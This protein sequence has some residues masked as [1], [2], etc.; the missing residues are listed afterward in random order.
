VNFRL[1]MSAGELFDLISPI[2][3]V[4]AAILS[5]LVLASARR[6]LPTYQAFIVAIVTFLF[7]LVVFPLYLALLIMGVRPKNFLPRFRFVLPVAYLAVV[8]SAFATY[9]Y[10]DERSV[11][12]HLS[13]AS[14]AKV[15]HEHTAA[16]REYREALKLEDNAHT[17]KLLGIVLAD[18]GYFSEAITELRAA[19]LGGEKDDSISYRLADLYDRTN[20]KEE[21][22]LEYRRFLK[23][24]TC[25]Q[26]DLRCE[27]ARQQIEAVEKRNR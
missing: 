26:I 1:N 13:R 27:S 7:P 10:F 18:A 22:T 20:K 24:E 15:N 3:L 14:L 8:L 19:E 6:R 25:Q 16:I 23:S 4:C 11:D 17:H 21:S 5:S 2:A 12:A 9:R